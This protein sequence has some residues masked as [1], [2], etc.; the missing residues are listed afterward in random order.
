MPFA[1]YDAMRER[2][3]LALIAA[4][5][6]LAAAANACGARTINK[7]T[8]HEI[9][10]NHPSGAF[11]KD[12]VDVSSAG[13]TGP[14]RALVEVQLRAALTLKREGDDWAVDEV[15]LG[16]R[17]WEKLDDLLAAL[18]EIKIRAARAQLERVAEAAARYWTEHS[19]LPGFTDYVSLSDALSPRYL[20]PLIRVDPW[21]VPL[22]AEPAGPDALKLL[23]AGPDRILGTADDISLTR[24]FPR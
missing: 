14:D 16:R 8:A 19:A 12:E 22:A 9:I 18:A 1:I 21:Q 6:L 20:S 7:K 23:S 24:S 13:Q 5:L 10:V 17:E 3:P 11:D 2:L 15:R 4:L